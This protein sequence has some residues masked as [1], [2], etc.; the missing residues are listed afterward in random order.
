[1]RAENH[2]LQ[3]CPGDS[4]AIERIVVMR[5]QTAGML[6]MGARHRRDLEPSTSTA[7]TIGRSKQSFLITTSFCPS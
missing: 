4:Q 1:V 2:P 5:R 6:G 7:A 3:V